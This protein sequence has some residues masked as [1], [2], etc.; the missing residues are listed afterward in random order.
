LINK[1]LSV[2]GSPAWPDPVDKLGA[3]MGQYMQIHK[4]SNK[5]S[6]NCSD[7]LGEETCWTFVS[8]IYPKEQY[9]SAYLIIFAYV[10][11]ALSVGLKLLMPPYPKG[12]PSSAQ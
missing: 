2:S 6:P 7:F 8:A 9:L 12:G 5:K 10:C 11:H 4:A 1:L 3:K